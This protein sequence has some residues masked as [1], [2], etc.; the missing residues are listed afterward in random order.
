MVS[1]HCRLD[2]P[3]FRARLGFL[4]TARG[5]M[6]TLNMQLSSKILVDGSPKMPESLWCRRLFITRSRLAAVLIM[7]L[8]LFAG[9]G[10]G[11]LQ[12]LI[13]VMAIGPFILRLPTVCSAMCGSGSS[14]CCCTNRTSVQWNMFGSMRSVTIYRSTLRTT[15]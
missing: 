11:G 1:V 8:A 13:P 2:A 7:G 9:I 14:G 5:V 15:C 4:L 3:I 12:K 10:G 6:C